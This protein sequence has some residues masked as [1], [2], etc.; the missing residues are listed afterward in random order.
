MLEIIGYF[1]IFR[2][3]SWSPCYARIDISPLSVHSD[4]LDHLALLS[5]FSFD[6]YVML[7]HKNRLIPN[8]YSSSLNSRMLEHAYRRRLQI[9]DSDVSF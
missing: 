7:I 1:V 6:Y 3:L 4:I 5:K 9:L 8:L 2:C